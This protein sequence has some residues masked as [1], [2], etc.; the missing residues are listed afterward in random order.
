MVMHRLRDDH[1]SGLG[2]D[3]RSRLSDDDRR[4][5]RGR[6][7][8]LDH[9]PRQQKRYG[10][11]SQSF[12]NDHLEIPYSA[13]PSEAPCSGIPGFAKRIRRMMGPTMGMTA[14]S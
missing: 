2:D 13:D 1:R 7:S 12:G 11:G 5:R 6:R 3:H 8:F 14:I 9:A 4:R 10:G